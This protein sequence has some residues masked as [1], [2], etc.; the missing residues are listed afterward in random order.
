MQL[1]AKWFL[2][3]VIALLL[4][5]IVP[6]FGI[7]YQKQE[8]VCAGSLGIQTGEQRLLLK[9]RGFELSSRPLIFDCPESDRRNK[10][11]VR[12]LPKS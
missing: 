12:A 3:V 6:M 11:E 7:R 5:L 2:V 10:D 9:I 8:F 1:P 4:L